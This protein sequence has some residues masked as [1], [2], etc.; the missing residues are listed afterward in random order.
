MV[1]GPSIRQNPDMRLSLISPIVLLALGTAAE[2]D[3]QD[4]DLIIRNARVWTGDSLRPRAEAIAV[5]GDRI[6]AVG[7]N[8]DAD[9]HRGARTRVIDATGRF[10]TPGF[11]D[12]HTHFASADGARDAREGRGGAHE[13]RSLAHRR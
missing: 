7:G 8:A 3:A 1:P 10:V 13:P 5:R 11:I 6:V 12:D 4:A 2:L 9:A